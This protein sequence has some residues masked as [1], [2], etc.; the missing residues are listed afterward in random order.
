MIFLVGQ[1]PAPVDSIY[2]VYFDVFCVYFPTFTTG[3]SCIHKWVLTVNP[4]FCPSN[5]GLLGLTAP[6]GAEVV[7]DVAGQC[8]SGGAN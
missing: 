7:A 2:I 4:G 6:P 5:H 1:M 8:G 3:L